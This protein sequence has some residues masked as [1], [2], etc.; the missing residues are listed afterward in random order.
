MRKTRVND[1]RK[2]KKNGKNHTR[3]SRKFRGGVREW[4][5]RQTPFL[6]FARK[7]RERVKSENNIGNDPEDVGKAGRILGDQWKAMSQEEKNL[8]DIKI[9]NTLTE[10]RAKETKRQALDDL[11][12]AI[13]TLKHDP[14]P[15]TISFVGEKFRMLEEEFNKRNNIDEKSKE[16]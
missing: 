9:Q 1:L 7:N 6:K 10:E 14:T 2:S 15:S 12:G 16:I 3:L 4:E 5:L 13:E 11:K 8:Y